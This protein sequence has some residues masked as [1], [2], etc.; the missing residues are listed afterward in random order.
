MVN[1]L[2]LKLVNFAGIYTATGRTEFEIDRSN[3]TN[4]IVLVLGNNGSGKSSL[5]NEITLLPLEN[6][7]GRSESRIIKGKDGL[8]EIDLVKDNEWLY[9]IRIVYPAGKTT[10]CYI[11]KS[12]LG[13]TNKIELNPNGNVSSYLDAV[14]LELGVTKCYTNIGYLSSSV[15]NFLQMKPTERNSFISE[16]I[17]D[18]E[19]FLDGY[20]NVTKKIYHLKKEID[21]LNRDIGKMNSMNSE[22]ELA[23]VND[24]IKRVSDTLE[25]FKS[26]KSI[27]GVYFGQFEKK[28]ISDADLHNMKNGI[29]KN[30]DIL[31]KK[32]S[33]IRKNAGFVKSMTDGMDV[34]DISK[35]ILLTENKIETLTNNLISSKERLYKLKTYIDSMV[36]EV[37]SKYDED[38]KYTLSEIISQINE[39]EA[40]RDV[41][42]ELSESD[43]EIDKQLDIS[44]VLVIDNVLYDIYYKICDKDLKFNEDLSTYK[45]SVQ[46]LTD[47]KRRL[48]SSIEKKSVELDMI[49]K[50]IYSY[51]S[52]TLDKSILRLRPVECHVNCGIVNELMNYY[53]ND[54]IVPALEK[55][56]EKLTAEINELKVE[57]ENVAANLLKCA[58]VEKIVSYIDMVIYK[59]LEHL[60]YYPES[61]MNI[62][63][64]SSFKIASSI[65]KL[66]DMN[67]KIKEQTSVN[68]KLK[69][70]NISLLSLR[71]IHDSI[72]NKSVAET[73]ITESCEEYESLQKFICSGTEELNE[74]TSN[75]EKMKH[76]DEFK[77]NL[78]VEIDEYNQSATKH[79]EDLDKLK[80]YALNRYWMKTCSDCVVKADSNINSLQERLDDLNSRKEKLTSV[81]ISKQ[82]IE[83]LRNKYL[84]TLEKYNIL[85]YIWSPKIGYPSWKIQNFTNLLTEETNRDLEEMWG[86]DLKIEEIRIGANEFSIV[87]NR[88]GTIIGDAVACS[89]GEQATLSLALSFA[90]LKLNLSS[91]SYNII[92]LDELDGPLDVERRSGFIDIVNSRLDDLSCQTCFIVSHNNEFDAVNCDVVLLKGWKNIPMRLDNKNVLISI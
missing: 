15:S 62:I 26:K 40:D 11:L 87:V 72:V 67:A 6:V 69:E 92:R 82:Q 28:T 80:S 3:S 14:Y 49:N 84:K 77:R 79:N 22:V 20:K 90:I 5:L 68:S 21:V 37:K 57:L 66:L 47:Q 81:V 4:N 86:D 31:K 83:L 63:N 61:F 23:S 13:D 89:S 30:R 60:K 51:T 85:S 54:R 8:K 70:I 59:N 75:L 44:S 34:D 55:D 73:K 25:D 64:T 19:T 2:R 32:I 7:E 10:K 53:E 9:E 76:F 39:L 1:L 42:S 27:L 12:K 74:L 58:E 24:E 46:N 16:W 45:T 33:E 71:N 88:S 36:E 65:L 91:I 43:T 78:D 56:S 50:R 48:E 29:L 17:S 38:N 52:N 18:I 41:L 35:K